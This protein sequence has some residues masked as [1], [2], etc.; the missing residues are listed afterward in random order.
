[1]RKGPVAAERRQLTADMRLY[2]IRRNGGAEFGAGVWSVRL[3]CKRSAV[4]ARSEPVLGR[5]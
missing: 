3:Q 4:K 5:R 2:S 1:M